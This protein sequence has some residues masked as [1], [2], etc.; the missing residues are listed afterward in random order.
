MNYYNPLFVVV[1]FVVA[2]DWA[3]AAAAA[4]AVASSSGVEF[5]SYFL[6]ALDFVPVTAVTAR[7]EGLQVVGHCKN[8]FLFPRHHVLL[9]PDGSYA[10]EAWV[11]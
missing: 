4:A 3:F 2:F 11:P 6:V 10:L 8:G 5:V 9:L 1:A 7:L